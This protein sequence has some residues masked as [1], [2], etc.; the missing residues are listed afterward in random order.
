MPRALGAGILMLALAA[1]LVTAAHGQP[2]QAPNPPVDEFGYNEGWA[3]RGIGSRH[4]IRR[5][6][7]GRLVQRTAEGGASTGRI[8]VRWGLVQPGRGLKR[9]CHKRPSEHPK[10]RWRKIDAVYSA[11]LDRGIRPVLDGYSA[12]REEARDAVRSGH[13]ELPSSASLL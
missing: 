3:D 2:E 1:V 7:R 13:R 9:S 10:E 11:M 6:G 5:R 4:H 12:P 8:P